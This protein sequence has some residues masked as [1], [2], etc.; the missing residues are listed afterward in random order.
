MDKSSTTTATV[1]MQ[2]YDDNTT[3]MEPIFQRSADRTQENYCA[4]A[5]TIGTEKIVWQC[6]HN[7]LCFYCS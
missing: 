7:I 6:S 5:N 4:Y 1:Y 2:C 3:M